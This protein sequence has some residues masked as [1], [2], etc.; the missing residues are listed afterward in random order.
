MLQLPAPVITPESLGRGG[1]RVHASTDASSNGERRWPSDQAVDRDAAERAVGAVYLPH[2]LLLPAGVQTVDLQFE[3]A[4]FGELTVGRVAYGRDVVARVDDVSELLIGFNLHGRAEM[5]SGT[6]IR[7]RVEPGSGVIFP[8]GAPAQISLSE[9]CAVLGLMLSHATLEIELEHLLGRSLP[10][11]LVLEFEV[12]I[13][14]ALRRMWDPI[15]RLLLAELR[16]PTPLT[17]NPV[18][19]RRVQALVLDA[20]LLGHQHNHRHLLDR[21]T[22]AGPATAVEQAVRLI[23]ERS[24][25]NWSTA[26]LAR[27]VHLSVR[28]LQAGFR[29]DLGVPP[30]DYL[31]D[32]RMHRVRAALLAA[33]AHT[34]TVRA[35]ATAHGFVHLGRFAAAYRAAY[36]ESPVETLRRAPV[37]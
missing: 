24:A 9:D 14:G 19:A 29:R 26:D 16:R 18:A 37:S 10:E 28:A 33:Q 36:G 32:V 20:L 25:E 30:M 22:P 5:T 8:T 11:P 1:E 15:L 7:H 6:G 31:R 12:E 17:Q 2:R 35:V 21:L 13:R 23:E 27:E 3:A 4:Q 34:T